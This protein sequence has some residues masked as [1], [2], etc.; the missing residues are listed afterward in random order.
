MGT[1]DADCALFDA[2]VS[3]INEPT[4]A[5]KIGIP[6]DSARG[7][8]TLPSSTVETYGQFLD[9]L[10]AF[11]IHLKRYIGGNTAASDMV[12]ARSE[13][14]ALLEETFRNRG[15]GEAAFAAARD[16]TEGGMRAVLDAVTEQYKTEEQAKH[17]LRIFKDAMSEM[18]WEEKVH[19][20]RGAMKRLGP[21][22]PAELRNEPA[23]RF[24]KN[25]EVIVRAYVQS[26]DRIG[27]LLRTM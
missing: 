1:P 16:G 25:W 13:A 10:E 20:I 2:I 24:V 4:L 11:Y 14:I 8:Y 9:I 7:S 12:K 3:M 18:E 6:V 27:Q 23:E 15:R 26:S 5:Q 17:V 19:C 21:L 22:L